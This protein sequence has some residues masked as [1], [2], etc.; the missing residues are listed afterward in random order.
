MATKTRL[1][2]RALWRMGEG[3]V[4][5]ELVDGAVIE[6]APAGG[7]HGKMTGR[8]YRKLA[9]HV[10]RYGGGEV[11]VGAV[12]FVLALPHDPERV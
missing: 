7:I 4:R 5:R 12:G 8:L 1:T 10:E 9:E 2:A 11:L 3:D 6:M